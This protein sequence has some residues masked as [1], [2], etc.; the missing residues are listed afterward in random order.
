MSKKSRDAIHTLLSKHYR[1]V[2]I[3]MI[4]EISDL[5]ALVAL[6]PDLVFLGMEFVTTNHELGS[7]D[8]DKVWL[9]DYLEQQGIAHTGSRAASHELEHDKS[10]AKQRMMD[11]GLA[12]KLFYV[13]KQNTTVTGEDIELSYPLFVKPTS[14]GGGAGIDSRSVVHDFEQLSSKV[15]L[16][17]RRLQS[18]S[19]VEEYL[20]G[21]EFSVAVLKEEHST[22]FVVM[23]VELIA[24]PDENG[25]RILSGRVKSA[26]AEHVIEVT[27]RVVKEQVAEL[28]MNA[29]YALGARDYGRIDIRMDK[30]GV[31]QFLEA[32]LIPSLIS[33]Y[34]SFPKAC[35]INEEMDYETMILRITRLGMSH[36]PNSSKKLP[37]FQ[38]VSDA[39]LSPFESAIEPV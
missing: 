38:S 28:A 36:N 14:C 1:T 3:T 19:L 9:A 16:I 17:A 25:I 29:F 26:D 22:E 27:D 35:F 18:D 37:V 6:Q 15:Q 11:S 8:P 34:G 31:P 33:G 13:A 21:R 5:E 23:P 24:P 2:G 10:K 7:Q 4:D 12:T 20:T 32:N 39:V 30:E